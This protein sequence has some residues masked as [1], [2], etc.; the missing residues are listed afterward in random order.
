MHQ[1]SS[2]FANICIAIVIISLG[3]V[4]FTAD[5][6]HIFLTVSAPVFSGN[7]RNSNVS[8]MI[9][10]SDNAEQVREMM[11]IFQ[12]RGVDAT[13][14]VTG[15]FVLRNMAVVREMAKRFEIGN[16]SFTHK[17]IRHMREN[18][19]RTHIFTTHELVRNV[20][21]E[22]ERAGF[23]MTLFS[24]PFGSFGRSTLRVAQSLR[25]TTVMW[26]RDATDSSYNNGELVYQRA[27]VNVMNGDIILLQPSI[28]TVHVLSR[29]IDSITGQGLGL[30]RISD[31]L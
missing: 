6:N 8:L 31:N 1:K 16:H 10:V 20:T 9:S 7:R 28:Y 27:T 24:P 4:V 14:F 22:D 13:F 26:S 23:E 5:L 2:L 18:D 19:Q 3:A 29:I 21:T 25:Y 30:V 11:E 12:E 17:D 15:D